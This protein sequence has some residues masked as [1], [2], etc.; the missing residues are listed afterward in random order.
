MLSLKELFNIMNY[1]KKM[2]VNNK[3]I[4]KIGKKIKLSENLSKKDIESL[5]KEKQKV[6]K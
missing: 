1:N 5:I 3:P 2:L 4:K 6:I